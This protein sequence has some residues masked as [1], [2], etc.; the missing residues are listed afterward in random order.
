MLAAH[1]HGL[2]EGSSYVRFMDQQ[3]VRNL[4]QSRRCIAAMLAARIAVP[5][6]STIIEVMPPPR[7]H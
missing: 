1:L 4:P 5:V 2:P 7:R 6:N 3:N